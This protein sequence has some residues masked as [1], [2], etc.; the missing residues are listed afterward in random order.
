[1]IKNRTGSQ[2]VDLQRE[3]QFQAVAAQSCFAVGFGD[4]RRPLFK[5]VLSYGQDQFSNCIYPVQC[6]YEDV[7]YS[8][9]GI[10]IA[11]K[12]IFPSYVTAI[13][14]ATDEPS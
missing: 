8:S 14:C 6:V 9:L 2:D 13:A 4:A 3:S 1:M 12:K 5:T 7:S 11:N 10:A